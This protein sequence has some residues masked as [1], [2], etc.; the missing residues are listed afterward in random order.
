MAKDNILTLMNL[1]DGNENVYGLYY[2]IPD[3]A[4]ERGKKK[5]TACSKRGE[6]TEKLWRDIHLNKNRTEF[7]GIAPIKEDGTVKF[8]AIDIDHYQDRNSH[9]DLIEKI[10]KFKLPL[11]VCTTKSGGAHCYC[12]VKSP[13]PAETMRSKLYE[14]A[15]IMGYSKNQ[16]GTETEIFPKETTILTDRGDIPS[17]INMPYPNGE[18]TIRYC[19]D[20]NMKHLTLE[21]FLEYASK[22]SIDAEQFEK[23]KITKTEILF[24]GPP[25][26]NNLCSQKFPAG[27]RNDALYNLGVYAKKAYPDSWEE[28]VEEYNHEYLDPPCSSQEVQGVIKSLRKKSYKYKCQDAPIS[29]FCN[30]KLCRLKKFGVNENSNMPVFGTLTKI[31]TSP[32]IWFLT[33]EVGTEAYRLE[34][35]TEDLQNPRKFQ[36]RCMETANIMPSI[37][38]MEVWE[39]LIESVLK[40]VISVEMPEDSSPHGI[41]LEHL[42]RF[43]TTKAMAKTREE[44]LIGR[45]Y[46]NDGKVYFRMTDFYAYLKRQKFTEASTQR[47]ATWLRNMD[48]A[49]HSQFNIKGK[50]IQVWYI[51]E[52][53]RQDD[54]SLDVPDEL[55]EGVNY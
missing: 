28:K 5:G 55:T 36:K 29:A 25:C 38:K 21:E 50:C 2:N 17:W 1:F 26:L 24:G 22:N 45:P 47:I 34:L 53:N 14:F 49:G 6:V 32:P 44:L 46:T 54:V 13:V 35:T 12:F 23:F 48:G 16:A 52:F 19:I 15:S 4:N 31:M 7:L 3:R 18:N 39:A 41:M 9:Q 30:P 11:V 27:C 51:N 10:S 20:N 42:E 8:G 37:P 40:D 43:C 33:V